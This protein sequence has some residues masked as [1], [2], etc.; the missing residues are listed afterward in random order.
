METKEGVAVAKT[1]SVDDLKMVT[2][3]LIC[4]ESI[5]IDKYVSNRPIFIC[6]K[7]RGAILY[8][9]DKLDKEGINYA[10]YNH[11]NR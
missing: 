8:M 5:E 1:I 4:N 3:C 2:P 7:C 11:D 10:D 6:Q 9:R